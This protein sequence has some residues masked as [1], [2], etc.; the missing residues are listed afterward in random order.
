MSG[1][2]NA[3]GG[4][5]RTFPEKYEGAAGGAQLVVSQ[6]AR[7]PK[8]PLQLDENTARVTTPRNEEPEINLGCGPTHR[9]IP[10]GGTNQ[11][12]PTWEDRDHAEC[13]TQ[14]NE[15]VE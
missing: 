5:G 14:K 8:K 3:G 12:R 1:S 2:A 9:I 4:A 10:R 7:A 15:C 6:N 11:G 13:D